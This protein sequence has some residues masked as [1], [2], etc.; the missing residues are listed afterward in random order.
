MTGT[1]LFNYGT[2][3]NQ[4]SIPDLDFTVTVTTDKTVKC[5]GAALLLDYALAI[6]DCVK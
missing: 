1:I 5:F 4:T 6:I 2:I 3:K